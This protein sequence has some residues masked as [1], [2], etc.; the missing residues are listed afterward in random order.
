VRCPLER[1]EGLH[2]NYIWLSNLHS[3]LFVLNT[4]D[5]EGQW[6]DQICSLVDMQALIENK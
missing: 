3:F 5:L 4:E 2:A 6:P 1:V